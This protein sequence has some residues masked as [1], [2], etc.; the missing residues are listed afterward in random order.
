MK[1]TRIMTLSLAA[2]HR[3]IDGVLAAQFMVS[4]KEMLEK[5]EQLVS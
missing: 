4:L 3:M 5:P 2:D 1:P